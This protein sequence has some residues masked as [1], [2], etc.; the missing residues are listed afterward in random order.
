MPDFESSGA[1]RASQT[2]AKKHASKTA[3]EAIGLPSSPDRAPPGFAIGSGDGPPPPY[4]AFDFS[5]S[6]PGNVDSKYKDQL[7]GAWKIV[8][9]S[10]V[11]VTKIDDFLVVL[12]QNRSVICWM[13]PSLAQ[14][15][16]T[17]LAKQAIKV[18]ARLL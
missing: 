18:I 6:A 1:A 8:T 14:F 9:E 12:C 11:S 3:F 7:R 5:I 16:D 15:K 13:S 4:E 2:P 10:I 17:Q